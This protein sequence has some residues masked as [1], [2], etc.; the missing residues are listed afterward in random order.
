MPLVP[1]HPPQLAHAGGGPDR[2]STSQ[3]TKIGLD[4][5]ML[6]IGGGLAAIGGYL[7]LLR[8]GGEYAY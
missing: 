6:Y 7:V 1:V 8:D 5:E 3:K 4:R 2:D